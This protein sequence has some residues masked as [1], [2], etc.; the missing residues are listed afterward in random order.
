MK[1]HFLELLFVLIFII[2]PYSV[3]AEYTGVKEKFKECKIELNGVNFTVDPRIELFHTIEV[4]NGIPLVN[5]IGLDYKEKIIENFAP[6]QNHPLFDFLKQNPIYGKLFKSIDA[7]MWFLIHLNNDFEWRKDVPVSERQ[8]RT[9]DS[10]RSLMKDFSKK[11]NYPKFFNSNL[12]LYKISLV[13]LTYNL[14]DFD[15]KNRLLDYCG[16]KDKKA[17]QFNVVLNFLGWGNFGPR[18]FKGNQAELYAIIAPEKTAIR[19][20]TFDIGALYKLIWHEFAHSFA[21]PAIEKAKSQFEELNYL[22]PPIKESMKAQAYHSWE[23]VVKEHLTEAI[24]CRMAAEKFG[25]DAAELNY[26]RLQK[27]KDWIYLNPLIKAL[28]YYELN[29]K[30]YPNLDSYIPKIF[31]SLKAVKQSEID[32]WLNEKEELKKP[33]LTS[34]PEIGAIYGRKNILFVLSTG[35]KD[36]DADQKLKDFITKFKSQ[37]PALM[38]AKII[39]DTTALKMD[40]SQYNLSVWGTPTGNQFL[41]KYLSQL[42]IRVYDDKI[43]GENIYNGTGYGVLMGWINPVNPE[44]VMAIYTAQNPA[45]LV[46]FNRIMN[47]GSNYHIFKNFITIKYGDFKRQSSAWLAK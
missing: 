46:D 21:N 34:I 42:P 37:R 25:E 19:V 27:G 22:W 4:M 11:S 47:G 43:I 6:F 8:N 35:E 30:A 32:L 24:A 39:D 16:I 26:V 1:K 18:I 20:P 13:T 38:D 5:F 29:R 15:E 44:N 12:D 36:K 41:K 17:F 3:F 9:L 31:E 28:N 33:N 14:P 45:T 2:N 7:P 40:L 23:V 10:L